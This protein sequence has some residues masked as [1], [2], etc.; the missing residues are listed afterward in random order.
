MTAPWEHEHAFSALVQQHFERAVRFCARMLGNRTEGEEVAQQ[1]FVRLY[2]RKS[3]LEDK[4]NP[5]TYLFAILRNACLDHIRSNKREHDKRARS[6]SGD[7]LTPDL[8]HAERREVEEALMKAVGELQESQREVVLLRF[9]E[10]LSLAD[11]AKATDQ[12][13]GAVAMKLA[14]A[15]AAL[16]EKLGKLPQ[17]AEYTQ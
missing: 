17:V 15:K 7:A 3:D 16:H 4:E 1:A 12:T 6:F 8:S 9:Y 13:L 2:E 11:V 14:R 5:E 10:G